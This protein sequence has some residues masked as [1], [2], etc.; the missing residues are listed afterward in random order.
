MNGLHL[1]AFEATPAPERK[2]LARSYDSD[3]RRGRRAG[4]P[5]AALLSAKFLHMCPRLHG[6]ARDPSCRHRGLAGSAPGSRQRATSA[7]PA[8]RSGA[9]ARNRRRRIRPQH[10]VHDGSRVAHL[11]GQPRGRSPRRGPATARERASR[12]LSACS[13]ST[14]RRART[15]R[16]HREGEGWLQRAAR[17]SP[18]SGKLD[19]K[20]ASSSTL[21]GPEL[22]A[23]RGLRPS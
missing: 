12:R 2:Q 9:T 6:G 5:S 16:A 13:T 23:L 8:S 1:P 21:L 20:Q 14:L 11:A 7:P 3:A 15:G 17:R 10:D 19:F 22:D 4:A 18:W